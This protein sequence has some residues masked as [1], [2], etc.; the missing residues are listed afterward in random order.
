MTKNLAAVRPWNL[1]GLA[2][3]LAVATGASYLGPWWWV[4]ALIVHFRPHLASA[5][6]VLL[7]LSVVGRRPLLAALCLA[8]LA[9]HG[10]P[11]LPYLGSGASA[12]AAGT[13][14]LRILELNMHGAGTDAEA[15]GQTIAAEQPDL[16]VLTEMPR[17]LDRIAREIGALPPF[18]AGE[19][20]PSP[21][22]VT[23]LSR[24]P[25]ERWRVERGSDG[26]ARVLFADICDTPAWRGCLRLVAIHAPR[27][28]GD[29]AR[30]QSEQL[31]IAAD[32]A[33]SAPDHRSILAG[34]FNLT[35]WAPEFAGLLAHGNLKDTGPYRGLLATWLSRLPFVG[36]LIDHVLVSPSVG[37]LANRVGADLGSDHLPVIADLVV[38]VEPH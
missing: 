1:A 8:L 25:I 12:H 14:N 3:L 31:A 20:P 27:P 18:R 7:A 10:A 15:L 38:P 23:L 29:G 11:L 16:V 4:P 22:A 30:R 26:T 34:D 5:S 6:L 37:I 9:I 2:G 36:L 32:L 33:S 24:W 21:W 19:L 13:R 17:N 35:P 28:F